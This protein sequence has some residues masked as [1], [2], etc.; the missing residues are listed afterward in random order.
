VLA[1]TDRHNIKWTRRLFLCSCRH[2]R[3]AHRHYRPGSDCAL[4]ECPR[5]ASW[6]LVSRLRRR[7][8]KVRGLVVRGGSARMS[9]LSLAFSPIWVGC[10]TVVPGRTCARWSTSALG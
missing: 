1:E 8:A 7:T 5:L 10:Y 3:D 2:S 9:P 6:N 4:C